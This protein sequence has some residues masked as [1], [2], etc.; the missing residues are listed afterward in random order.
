MAMRTDYTPEM[1]HAAA[2]RGA[3]W[4]D[5]RCPGWVQRIDLEVLQLSD[6]EVC[7]LGQ[8]AACLLQRETTRDRYGQVISEFGGTDRYRWAAGRGFDIVYAQHYAAGAV[9]QDNTARYEM[10]T[11]AWREL[12]RG[13]LE[14]AEPA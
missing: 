13:R 4:L 14:T 9:S 11:I 10:L 12:I 3:D 8:T 1:A 2:R 6:P 5:R 7:V